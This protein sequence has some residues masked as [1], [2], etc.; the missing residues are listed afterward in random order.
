MQSRSTSRKS[1]IRAWSAVDAAIAAGAK[2]YQ[3]SHLRRLMPVGPDELGESGGP[4]ATNSLL[5]KIGRALR[6]ERARGSAG[7]W[8]YDINRHMALA[9]AYVAE[10]HR[11]RREGGADAKP[12]AQPG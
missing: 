10:S 3:R 9:Q 2:N 7:H 12:S 5:L 8:T 6:G 1:R 11:L 4:Q